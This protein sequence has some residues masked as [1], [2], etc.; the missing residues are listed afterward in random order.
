MEDEIL[1]TGNLLRRPSG[2]V[3]SFHEY[4]CDEQKVTWH[5]WVKRDGS[6]LGGDLSVWTRASYGQLREIACHGYPKERAWA[7]AHGVN[8][9]DVGKKAFEEGVARHSRRSPG[10]RARRRPKKK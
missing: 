9:E 1:V 4:R 10:E 5:R 8:C 2:N 7:V 6:L 3:D